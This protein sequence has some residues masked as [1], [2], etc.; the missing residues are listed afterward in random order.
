VVDGNGTCA[1]PDDSKDVDSVTPAIVTDKSPCYSNFNFAIFRILLPRIMGY[2]GDDEDTY[3]TQYVQIVQ[4]RVFKP[5]GITDADCKPPNNDSY[6]IAH[7]FPGASSND[8]GNRR[9]YCGGEGWYLSVEDLGAVL[10]SLNGADGRILTETQFRDMELHPSKHALGW[11]CPSD[12]CRPAY[13]W[14]E[15]NGMLQSD[16]PGPRVNTS[17]A[18]F[19]STNGTIFNQQNPVPYSPGA[20]GVLFINS[21]VAGA[22][23]LDASTV[24]QQAFEKA[25]KPKP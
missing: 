18:I 2:G 1:S 13:R 22:P 25:A 10:L 24:L 4:D 9:P 21:D 14:V 11:D 19:G 12:N 3:A 16:K 15:K 7:A 8:F 23:T 6:A 20:V 5:L 17:I